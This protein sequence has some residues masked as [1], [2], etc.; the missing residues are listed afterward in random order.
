MITETVCEKVGY[1]M[2]SMT[3]ETTVMKT[4]VV[5]IYFLC[6]LH[7]NSVSA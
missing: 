2:I 5:Y 1:V 7:Y 6:P 4:D 3:V